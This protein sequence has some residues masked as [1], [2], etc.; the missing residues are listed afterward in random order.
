M[1]RGQKSRFCSECGNKLSPEMKFCGKCGQKD[2]SE[3][4]NIIDFKY[5]LTDLDDLLYK[6]NFNEY[7]NQFI[8][9]EYE[10]ECSVDLE[11]SITN[12]IKINENYPESDHNAIKAIIKGI[13]KMHQV[14]CK[15]FNKKNIDLNKSLESSLII[16]KILDSWIK[17]YI[18]KTDS[19]Y[20][21]FICQPQ[22]Y[23]KNYLEKIINSLDESFLEKSSFIPKNNID[24]T[25]IFTI[26]SM[27]K[28]SVE[29]LNLDVLQ[30]DY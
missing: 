9:S 3:L 11:S 7:L 4:N 20:F 1:D 19:F 13:F 29:L 5:D 22:S 30:R 2:I 25:F 23:V 16:T 17:N 8:N 26:K 21:D 24:Q 14:L 12:F 6:T 10:I 15:A 18:E 27:K 28:I